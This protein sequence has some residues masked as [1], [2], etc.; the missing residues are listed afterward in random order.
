MAQNDN[1]NDFDEEDL[2]LQRFVE[3]G[4]K[5]KWTWIV[6]SALIVFC[7]VYGDPSQWVLAFLTAVYIF[8]TT[9]RYLNSMP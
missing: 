1:I 8:F 4:N 7:L 9:R 6:G 2:E 3:Q 5:L